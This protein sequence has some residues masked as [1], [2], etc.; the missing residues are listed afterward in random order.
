MKQSLCSMLDTQ[1]KHKWRHFIL[2]TNKFSIVYSSTIKLCY[3]ASVMLLLF[4]V[5]VLIH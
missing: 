3:F 5:Q 2:T 4:S 1:N